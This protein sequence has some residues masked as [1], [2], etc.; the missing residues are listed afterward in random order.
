MLG[1]SVLN[2]VLSLLQGREKMNFTEHIEDMHKQDDKESGVAVNVEQKVLCWDNLW[3]GVNWCREPCRF[4]E[5]YV[6]ALKKNG[7]GEFVRWLR[8]VINSWR[9]TKCFTWVMFC[10]RLPTFLAEQTKCKWLRTRHQYISAIVERF[11][12]NQPKSQR[13]LESGSFY[14]SQGEIR[15]QRAGFSLVAFNCFCLVSCVSFI[16]SIK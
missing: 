2:S 12:V 8:W 6:T 14:K 9:D 13:A 11:V 15:T 3:S 16:K 7:S 4:L 5:I 10:E 1:Q